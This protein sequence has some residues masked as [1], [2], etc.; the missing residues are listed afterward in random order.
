MSEP[1]TKKAKLRATP[2]DFSDIPCLELGTTDDKAISIAN[3]YTDLPMQSRYSFIATT[4][5]V[6]DIQHLIQ[7]TLTWGEEGVANLQSDLQTD[8]PTESLISAMGSNAVTNNSVTNNSVTELFVTGYAWSQKHKCTFKYQMQPCQDGHVVS[9]LYTGNIDL[10]IAGYLR[11]VHMFNRA[12]L[13]KQIPHFNE[14]RANEYTYLQYTYL[15]KLPHDESATRVELTNMF[16]GSAL[17]KIST[18]DEELPS[19]DEIKDD[20]VLAARIRKHSENPIWRSFMSNKGY[21]PAIV[22]NLVA[23]TLNSSTNT[24]TELLQSLINFSLDSINLV[25]LKDAQFIKMVLKMITWAYA[26]KEIKK[27][28]ICLLESV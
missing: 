28:C 21:I 15:P 13:F 17:E 10:F 27:L 4:N 9:G 1:P 19:I 8:L 14:V 24:S 25:K 20:V 16:A 3:K 2:V 26:T 5:N 12:L 7:A 11:T 23:Q 18:S 6:A 22:D